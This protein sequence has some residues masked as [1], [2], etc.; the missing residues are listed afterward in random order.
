[1]H[2][3]KLERIENVYLFLALMDKKGWVEWIEMDKKRYKKV[4]NGMPK[5]QP[6]EIDNFFTFLSQT[7]YSL[8]CH[9][10]QGFSWI[11]NC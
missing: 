1:M 4:Q 8:S 5:M 10:Q 6:E 3:M 2:N 7:F 11:K 9:F